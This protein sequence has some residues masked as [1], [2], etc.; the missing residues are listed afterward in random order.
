MRKL[1]TA[2]LLATLTLSLFSLTFTKEVLGASNPKVSAYKTRNKR[3]V[4][5]NFTSIQNLKSISYELTY[6][7]NKGPQ[8]AGGTINLPKRKRRL[9]R[10]LLLG[11]C[12]HK[13]CTYHK[14]VKNI[15]L[16][17]DFVL[18]SGGVVSYEKTIQ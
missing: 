15:K 17:V 13:V 16:S 7:S 18:K 11:T 4:V 2:L 9:S 12:S 6:D 3:S 1:L 14:D 8:G 10:S 5:V